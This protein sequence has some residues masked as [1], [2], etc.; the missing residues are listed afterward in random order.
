ML[1]FPIQWVPE[2]ERATQQAPAVHLNFKKYG[3]GKSSR[4]VHVEHGS[5][6]HWTYRTHFPKQHSENKTIFQHQFLT[7][8]GPVE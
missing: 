5:G 1:I 8:G 7:E 3:T 2:V 4:F 6:H